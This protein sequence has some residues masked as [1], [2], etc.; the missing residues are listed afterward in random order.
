MK[1]SEVTRQLT[2]AP[3]ALRRQSIIRTGA[4]ESISG[5]SSSEVLT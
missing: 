1:G 3:L 5:T 4:I 2:R